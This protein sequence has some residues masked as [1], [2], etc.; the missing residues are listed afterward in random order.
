MTGMPTTAEP[1][2]LDLLDGFRLRHAGATIRLQPSVQ[3]LLAFLALHDRPLQR[4]Y[5]AG[6]LWTDSAQEC[7][8]ANLRTALWR[9]HRPSC[10]LVDA[11]AS[12]LALAGAVTVDLREATR[13]AQRVLAGGAEPDDLPAVIA[14]GEL[15]PDLYDDW[16]LIE[17][18]RFRQLRLHA[19][20]RLCEDLRAAGRFAEATEAG[21]AAVA[22]EPLR[23]S[24]HRALIASHLAEGNLGE[25]AR[26]YRLYRDL[27]REQLG[28][29]PSPRLRALV[30]PQLAGG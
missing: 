27:A 23:E 5:V 13:R 7:A 16:I 4:L 25:A 30:G 20:E 12:D 6:R 9:L 1:P 26:Q 15:L 3:R 17:R 8:N 10:A 28:M 29:A 18:E 11:T 2:R 22:T 21:L 19:L 24:A 14:A